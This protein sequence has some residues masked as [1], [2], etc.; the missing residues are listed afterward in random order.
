MLR[1]I[2]FPAFVF[3]VLLASQVFSIRYPVTPSEPK[4][5][6]VETQNPGMKTTVKKKDEKVPKTKVRIKVFLGS[7]DEL[8]GSIQAPEKLKFKHYKGS[9]R[10]QKT[11][12]VNDISLIEILSFKKNLIRKKGLSEFYEFK[13]SRIKILMKNKNQFYL[14]YLFKFLHR[15]EIKTADG[16]TT[17]YSFFADEFNPTRG[18]SEVESLKKDYHK[19]N[20]H[21]RSVKTLWFFGSTDNKEEKNNKEE[22]EKKE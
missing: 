8:N 10:Y 22:K 13:P 1:K 18:W 20:P 17:I 2:A 9:L 14:N 15:F 11:I 7:G 4:S 16:T 5:P 21:P 3:F 12:A 6:A 19:H